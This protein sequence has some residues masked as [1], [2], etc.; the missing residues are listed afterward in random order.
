MIYG[1]L[2]TCFVALPGQAPDW[3][4]GREVKQ[5]GMH[6]IWF[7]P[8]GLNQ[9]VVVPANDCK[10]LEDPVKGMKRML[11]QQVAMQEVSDANK[12]ELRAAV[13]RLT[14]GTQEWCLLNGYGAMRCLYDNFESCLVAM[15]RKRK[16]DA[17]FCQ[18][19]SLYR[20]GA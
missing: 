20:K 12:R 16:S 15:R 14:V 10:Y 11:A 9:V 2:V 1:I 3:H 6:N 17:Y 7:V 5:L 18:K 19:N 13:E 8:H 4:T